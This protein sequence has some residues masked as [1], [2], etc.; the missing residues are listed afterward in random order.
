[1]IRMIIFDLDSTLAPI[2]YGMGEEELKL[3]K[4]IE[5]TGVRVAIC[6]GKTCDYLCGFLRQIGL[7]NP[8]LIGENGAVIRFGID[9]PPKQHYRIPFSKE[10][11]ESLREIRRMLEEKYPHI[12][13]QPN[14]VGVTP[15]PTT[16]E[17]FEEIADLLEEYRTS[18]K[19]VAVYRHV[20]SFDIV[21][22]GIDKAVGISY[23]LDIMK[24]T[25]KEIIAVGDGVNDYA[26]FAVAGFS[27]GV[28]VK[29][30]KRVDMNCKSTLEML[31]FTLEYL[32]IHN[33]GDKSLT[34]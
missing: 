12:W 32:K 19:E 11:S 26:M 17:E 20:D 1:M 27:I 21:P 3:L 4:K 28:N 25:T 31:Q 8:I 33:T 9:L 6:S 10:A 18:M 29:E 23:L 22:V 7:K 15:F 2:G 24:I 5:N 13:F 14:K 16:E 34:L 30:A